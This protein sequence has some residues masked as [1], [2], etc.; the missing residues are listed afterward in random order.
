[1]SFAPV[2]AVAIVAAIVIR[3]GSQIALVWIVIHGSDAMSCADVDGPDRQP[4]GVHE[5]DSLGCAP[6]PCLLAGA[7]FERFGALAGAAA[8]PSAPSAS[9]ASGSVASGRLGSGGAP[10]RVR[11]SWR[12]P[13]SLLRSGSDGGAHRSRT[14]GG[15]GISAR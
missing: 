9:S 2:A 4:E 8:A 7:A 12:G 11:S 6:D 5:A 3:T 15:R 13:R 10:R 1:M 14:L